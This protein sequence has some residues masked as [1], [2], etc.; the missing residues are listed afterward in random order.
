MHKRTLFPRGHGFRM[1]VVLRS[2]CIS[3]R[4][5][6]LYRSTDCRCRAGAAM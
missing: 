6:M 5:T 4:L 2:Q 3:A 1:D